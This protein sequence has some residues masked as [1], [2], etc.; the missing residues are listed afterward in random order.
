MKFKM[1]KRGAKRGKQSLSEAGLV[2]Q[3][4]LKNGGNEK[5]L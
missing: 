3:I 5:L 1:K 2:F 4:A